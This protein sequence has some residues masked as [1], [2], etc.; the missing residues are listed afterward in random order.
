MDNSIS[1][2]STEG[3]SSKRSYE[4]TLSPLEK[5]RQTDEFKSIHE[6]HK[7]KM[8]AEGLGRYITKKDESRPEKK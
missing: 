6:S 3:T 2:K 7:N 4:E 1:N 8:I 5:F